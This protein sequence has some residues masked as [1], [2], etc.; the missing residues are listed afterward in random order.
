MGATQVILLEHIDR[1]GG[2]GDTVNVKQ[3]FARN[4][5]LP[6]GKALRATA[7]NIA[8]F[9]TQKSVLEAENKK[10]RDAAQK[11][12]KKLDGLTIDLIRQASEGGQLYG[13]VSARDISDEVAEKSGL[14]I[15]RNMVDLNQNFKMIGLFPVTIALHPEVKLDVTVN[16]ARTESE[17]KT[18]RE[19][20][21]A[22]IAGAMEEAEKED[23][24]AEENAE[25]AADAE[26]ETASEENAE[27]EAA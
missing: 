12:A 5:L 24:S 2:I 10:K 23:T 16:I 14:P 9:E 18:Q 7:D 6:Q 20:G 15:D 4:F 21:K 1:L 19:L 3:G 11:D 17:A 22:L 25:E 27:S 26:A 8:F 13:S